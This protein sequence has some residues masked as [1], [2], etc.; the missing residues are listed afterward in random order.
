MDS[1]GDRE[2]GGGT[3]YVRAALTGAASIVR[4]V[5]RNAGVGNGSNK[6]LPAITGAGERCHSR[7]IVWSLAMA[8]ASSMVL[9]AQAAAPYGTDVC[10][11]DRMAKLNCTANDVEVARVAV[12]NNVT[13]CRAG[14]LVTLDLRAFL[15]VNA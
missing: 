11:A 15:H 12:L 5:V 4:R 10:A 1:L 3:Y 13:T 14:E 8:L 9:S 2:R 7:S 6:P